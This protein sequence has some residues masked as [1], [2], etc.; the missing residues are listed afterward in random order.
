[1]MIGIDFIVFIASVWVNFFFVTAIHEMGHYLLAIKYGV[2]CSEFRIGRW[3][4]CYCWQCG[5]TLFRLSFPFVEGIVFMAQ[6]SDL[7]SYQRTLQAKKPYQRILIHTAGPLFNL[8]SGV[9]SMFYL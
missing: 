4:T 1:M 6:D 8:I 5:E 9:L 2:Y 3:G 7:V